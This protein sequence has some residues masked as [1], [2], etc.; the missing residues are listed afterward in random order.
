ML[1]RALLAELPVRGGGLLVSRALLVDRDRARLRVEL[2]L[3]LSSQEDH[4]LQRGDAGASTRVLEV[5]VEG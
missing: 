1:S 2:A 5:G 3:F 4:G